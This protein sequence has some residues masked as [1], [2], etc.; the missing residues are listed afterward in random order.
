MSF[1]EVIEK[2]RSIRAYERYEEEKL[3]KIL[4]VI[5]KAPSA[6][7]LPALWFI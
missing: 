4:D 7:N 2:R 1:F 3:V 5:R 6:D